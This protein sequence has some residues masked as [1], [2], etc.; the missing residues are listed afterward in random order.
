MRSP[1]GRRQQNATSLSSKLEDGA[2]AASGSRQSALHPLPV[3]ALDASDNPHM[4]GSPLRMLRRRGSGA[5]REPLT[6]SVEDQHTHVRSLRV[7]HPSQLVA[8]GAA[9]MQ[10]HYC[11]L[12]VPAD[13]RYDMHA[14][15]ALL[16]C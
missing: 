15:L 9:L 1:V 13:A 8:P 7:F 12:H 6:S 3:A 16:R 5:A 2:A 10:A 14:D 11:A 4:V